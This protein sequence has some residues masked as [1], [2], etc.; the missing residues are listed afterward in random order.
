MNP[1]TA[2]HLSTSPASLPADLATGAVPTAPA[3][4]RGAALAAPANRA[5]PTAAG[6]DAEPAQAAPAA[7]KGDVFALPFHRRLR[8]ALRALRL[9]VRDP[10][11][12]EQVF[13]LSSNIN[14][15]SIRRRMPEFYASEAG[16]RLFREDRSI[17]TRHVDFDA[18]ANLPDGTLGREYVRFLADRGLSP[19]IFQAPENVFDPHA[20]YVMKRMR[21]THDL[22]HLVTNHA[23]N[24]PGEVA[25]QAFTFG[26]VGAPSSALIALA[27]TLRHGRNHRGLIGEVVRAY[28]AGRRAA[29]LAAFAWEDH[30]ATP[31]DE[32]RELLGVT[33]VA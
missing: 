10:Y 24:P 9:L 26:Q 23:T 32:L 29:P 2:S 4:L 25:L 17:D 5:E 19:D 6:A 30:W 3:T 15:G 18:L 28:R 11:D 33:A 21:Q 20:S 22:W 8:R 13:E 14:V 7:P 31:L 12:T 1:T 16:Q 27:G